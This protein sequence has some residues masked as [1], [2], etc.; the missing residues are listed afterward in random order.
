MS[1]TDTPA[2]FSA[3]I[4]V[5]LLLVPGFALM[6][7]AAL[8]EAFRAANT[9]SGRALYAWVHI[10]P[11]GEASEASNGARIVADARAGQSIDCARLFV[12][13]GG[14]PRA[15]DHSVT[16]S[17]LRLLAR[18]GTVIGG[19]SGGPYVLARA[20]LLA[21][22]RAT[23]H[24][25]HMPAMRAQ[26]PDVLLE[27]GL[28]VIDGP[29][30]TCAGGTAG[31]DLA[32]ALIERDHGAGLAQQVGDWF[33]RTAARD[34][35]GPQRLSPAERHGTTNAAVLRALALIEARIER[36]PLREE[37]AR[38]A[39]VSLRQLERLFLAHL[40][41]GVADMAMTIRLDAAAQ[42]L[43]TTDEPVTTVALDC[44]FA[45]AA[46]FSRRFRARYG[47]APSALRKV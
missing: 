4:R 5:G 29:V 30:I 9:L 2:D 16:I 14:D 8:V 11:D 7:Y 10:S 37:L 1:K 12:F 40:G 47:V 42:R 39:G 41:R 24:W 26:F 17:W 33:I 6:G 32:L 19:V 28:Y 34:A 25:E 45:S 18:Q 46:H 36:P 27:S 13:A 3:P 31:L 43:R 35:G 21:G 15:F 23:V 22:R 20:G 44:G 38:A